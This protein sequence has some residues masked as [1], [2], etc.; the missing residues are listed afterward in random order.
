MLIAGLQKNSTIDFPGCFSAVI[1]SAGCNYRCF[2]CHNRNILDKPPLLDEAEV[3]AF[4]ERRAGL[5]DGVVFSGGEPT[6]QKDI[7]WWLNKAKKLGY[8]TKLDTNGS[9]PDVLKSLLTAGLVDFAAMDVKA[10][11]RLY[12]EICGA[13]ATGVKESVGLLAESGVSYEL[14]T[15]MIPQLTAAELKELAVL[16]PPDARWALQ[17]YRPQ[18]GDEEYLNGLEPYT[19]K[20]IAALAEEIRAVRP[21]VFARV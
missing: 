21:N 15:T 19:P 6:L 2:Y 3:S 11:L 1:F 8:K 10:P 18:E 16:V 13:P 4:L 14:R 5:I 20:Q 17:L 12:P 7:A 9:R